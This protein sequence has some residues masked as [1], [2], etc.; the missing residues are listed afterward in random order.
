MKVLWYAK[1]CSLIG[2]F[3]I[4][5][6]SLAESANEWQ[7][8][9]QIYNNICGHCHEVGVG[10]VLSGRDLPAAYFKT[11]ARSGRAAMPAFRPTELSNKDLDKI[12]G[13]LVS[14]G[15]SGK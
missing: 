7:S 8:G 14:R 3:L 6:N 13:F 1:L 9:K 5:T 15:E 10:P 11:I 4:T 12:A 2:F